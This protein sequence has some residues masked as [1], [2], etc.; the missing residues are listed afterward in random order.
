[1]STAVVINRTA[2]KQRLHHFSLIEE[3]QEL[4]ALAL[5]LE[6]EYQSLLAEYGYILSPKQKKQLATVL[7]ASG[8]VAALTL[9]LSFN[10]L[11]G[12]NAVEF[13]SGSTVIQQRSTLIQ[14]S[15]KTRSI[16]RSI[17]VNERV[18]NPNKGNAVQQNRNAILQVIRYAEGTADER[19][20]H[21]L[22]GGREVE[23]LSKHPGIC[24]KFRNTCSTAAGAY[25]FL[26]KTWAS[27]G[28][29]NFSPENQDKGAIEL[30]RRRGAL[31]DVDAGRVQD[32]ITKLS[33]EWASLP[34]WDGDTRGTY[35]QPVKS[36]RELYELFVKSGGHLVSALP[37]PYGLSPVTVINSETRQPEVVLA[38]SVGQ[39][40]Q[41]LPH[42][43][44]N[45]TP[46]KDEQIAGYTVTSPWGKRNTGIAGASTFHRGT[47]LDLPFGT[48]VYPIAE[49]KN[50][51]CW[52]DKNGGG[53][54]ASFD[55]P[56]LKKSFD[57]LHLSK[58]DTATKEMR[59]GSTG[60]GEAHLHITQR[61]AAG[62]KEPAWRGLPVRSIE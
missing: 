7:A 27:L 57:Y 42:E 30:I 51:R 21:R 59:S 40:E 16:E 56:S 46:A 18:L 19:G 32:A 12:E 54:V 25:Q 5:S 43:S 17:P 8:V 15:Y 47:D 37:V 29:A 53:N 22:F 34:R 33:P 6:L 4:Q 20:Y 48:R 41:Q 55:A 9:L 62:K 31:A 23:D 49:A 14:P 44:D 60:I 52:W 26:D 61:D 35:K 45:S 1:M 58:C 50:F 11:N 3:V 24:V 38:P 2:V 36:M 13:N 39:L 10:Q 28:L